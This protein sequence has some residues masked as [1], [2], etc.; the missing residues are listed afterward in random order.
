MTADA[1]ACAGTALDRSRRVITVLR[2]HRG[3][4]TYGVGFVRDD[5]TPA[6]A[7]AAQRRLVAAAARAAATYVK[8]WKLL[9][10]VGLYPGHGRRRIYTKL[11]L[12][13]S[14]VG[15]RCPSRRRPRRPARAPTRSSISRHE[16]LSPS[17]R[18]GRDRPSPGRDD[19]VL[20]DRGF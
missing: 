7:G 19:L 4:A 8:Q 5:K 2:C 11:H 1:A 10:T 17:A 18:S 14:W 3:R 12:M 16:I 6:V 13:D 15:W 20:A 9:F